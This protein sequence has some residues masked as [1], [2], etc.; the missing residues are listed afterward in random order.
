MYELPQEPQ[1]YYN[2]VYNLDNQKDEQ[3]FPCFCQSYYDDEGIL[4]DCTCGK[5][6]QEEVR[7]C[8]R[9]NANYPEFEMRGDYCENCYDDLFVSWEEAFE[10]NK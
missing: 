6:E 9:C 3:T 4:Q 5:C 8:M 10:R 7:E 1:D 2:K